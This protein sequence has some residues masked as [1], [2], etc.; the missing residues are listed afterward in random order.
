MKGTKV[1]PDSLDMA[2]MASLQS[3]IE[4]KDEPF[5]D[6]AKSLGISQDE[7]LSRINILL[8]TGVLRRFG[9]S[10]S[11]L[12]MGLHANGMVVC[13]VPAYRIARVGQFLSRLKEVTHCYQRRT[14]PKVWGYNMF[15][16]VHGSSRRSVEEYVASLMRRLRIKEHEILF[17]VKELKKTSIPLQ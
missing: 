8:K 3:G 9:A 2:I 7:V 5:S 16:M 12:R 13:K 1:I 14:I 10:V 4:I 17:S 15:F 11:P 6:I